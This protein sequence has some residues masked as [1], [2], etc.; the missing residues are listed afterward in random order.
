MFDV[1][2][3]VN[4]GFRG[5]GA[6]DHV[7]C[8]PEGR[9]EEEGTGTRATTNL[10]TQVVGGRG[11]SLRGNEGGVM[12]WVAEGGQSITRHHQTHAPCMA[13]DFAMPTSAQ[14]M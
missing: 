1:E 11:P 4:G 12:W 3:E 10:G 13:V 9:C 7:S 6:R 2:V 8:P 14:R 5:S